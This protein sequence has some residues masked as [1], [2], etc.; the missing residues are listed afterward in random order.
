M[1]VLST[2]Q[3]KKNKQISI[4]FEEFY[5]FGKETFSRIVISHK[6][7]SEFIVV[8]KA[9]TQYG[10]RQSYTSTCISYVCYLLLTLSTR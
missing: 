4:S 8:Y 9:M 3:E 5:I 2:T 7:V 6:S 1:I 10:P